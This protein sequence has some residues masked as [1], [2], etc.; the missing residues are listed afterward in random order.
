VHT[1][2][3]APAAADGTDTASPSKD[4]DVPCVTM[5]GDL[6]HRNRWR[7]GEVAAASDRWS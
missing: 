6:S 5:A 4:L 7:D 3:L 1:K 2:R